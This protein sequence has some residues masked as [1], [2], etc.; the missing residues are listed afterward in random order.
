MAVRVAVHHE[1]VYRFDREVAVAPHVV[2][3]RPAAHCRTPITGYSLTVEPAGHFLNWQQDPQGNHLARLVFPHK[4]REL[5]LRVDLVA[6]MVAV[7]AFDFFLEPH[8]ERFPFAYDPSLATELGPYRDV[9]AAA[10][11]LVEAFV[12][13]FRGGLPAGPRTDPPRTMDVLVALNRSIKDRVAYVIRMEPG[14]QRPE[15]TLLLGTG[16]C[17]DSAWLLV[18]A[19]RRLGLAARFCSG[20]LVQLAADTA[21]LDGPAGPAAD[22]TDLHAWAEIYLPGAGWVGLDPTS[23]LLTAEGHIPLAATPDPTTAA[24]VSGAV[25]PCRTELEVRMRVERLA[26]SPRTTKP[27][28][29]AQWQAIDALGAEVDRRLTAAGLRL[30]SGGEPTFVSIDDFDAPEWNTAAN[31]EEKRR[32]GHALARRLLDR[33]GQGGVILVQQGKWYPGEPLPRWALEVVWRRDG[34][35]I[36]KS[37][38]LIAGG[39]PANAGAEPRLPAATERTCGDFLRRLAVTLDVDESFVVPTVDAPVSDPLDAGAG[40]VRGYVLPLLRQRGAAEPWWRSSRWPVPAAGVP[41]VAGDSPAG[42][43]LPMSS[44]PWPSEADAREGRGI[45]RTAV[46]VEPRG[47]IV[48]VFLPPLDA[49]EAADADPESRSLAAAAAATDWLEL[50]ARVEAVAKAAGVPVV[51]EGYP[52]PSDSRF[53]RL[54]VTPDPGVIEVNVPPVATWTELVRLRETLDEE[55]RA[56]RLCAEK[57]EIDGLHAGTG[58]GDHIVLGGGTRAES[59]FLTKPWLLGDLVAYWNN[60]PSLSYLFAGRFVGPTSQAP[61][62]DEARHESLYELEL[63]LQELERAGSQVPPW[64]VDRVFRDILTDMTGNTHRTEFCIDK[65][66]SPD[67][68]GGRRGLLELRAF[69]MQP[70]VRMGL[71]AQLVVRALVARF[72]AAPRPPLAGR[73]VRWG[74][75][76]HDR[77]LLPHFL[78][79]D[80]RDVVM[81]LRRAGFDFE[82]EWFDCFAEFRFPRLGSVA[83]DGVTLELR[84][85]LEP[86]H[87]LGEEPVGGA[88]SRMV[89]SSLARV[90]V[91][92]SGLVSP[93]HVVACNGRRVPLVPAGTPGEFVGGVRYRAWQPPRCLHPTIPVHAPLVFDIVD[94]WSGRS[95][96][97]CTWHAVHPG[98]RN[99]ETRPVNALEAEGRRTARF[100]AGG[101]SPGPLTLPAEEPNP[102]YACTLD[103]RR[104]PRQWLS[105]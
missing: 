26:E 3:L 11:P 29:D 54:Q 93:R 99:Y 50:V 5:V 73:L 12:A 51:L 7:N 18:V 1:T 102:D 4:T 88:T 6:E 31:G 65:L 14:V 16:S 90:Q 41:L 19:A 97:G 81:D 83:H 94:L 2:R 30:T 82:P 68:A 45:V 34:V 40:R 46:V 43:R 28:T 15:E 24:P 79:G 57:F 74:T 63:A 103:L 36:W 105:E 27:V 20:Y 48:H 64:F 32:K 52:P 35:P 17:R 84:A 98:G 104:V 96:G 47:G 38:E 49:A 22:F 95:V 33:L 87:V 9:A 25:D 72:A 85:A 13:E 91:K 60:H 89:D 59:P 61:R 39:E 56:G 58:G 80:F 69:E 76:L 10:G 86:W 71:L 75:A 53:T 67:K 62:I 66:F 92:A 55:A 100:F 78:M 21:P 8:V 101:H 44:L 77:F 37:A 23:G 42:L 70:H